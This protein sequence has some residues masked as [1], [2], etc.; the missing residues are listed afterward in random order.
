MT[1]SENKE[2][3]PRSGPDEPVF[4]QLVETVRDY[5][6]FMLDPTGRVV[7]WNEGARRIKGYT[8]ED[9]IGSHFSRFYP[10]EAIDRGWPD[11]ELARAAADGR[12]EDESWRVRKD[13]T[14]FWANVVITALHDADGNLIGFSKVTRDLSE[15][16]RREEALRQSEERF[17][18]LVEGVRDYA[19]FMLDPQGFVTTWTVGAKELQGYEAEEIVGA[20]FSRFYPPDAIKRGWPERELRAA[21]M[22]GRFEDEGWRIRKDGSRFWANVLITALRD[23]RTGALIG[24]SKITRDLTE[25]RRQEQALAQSEER[26]RLLVDGVADYAI[27]MLDPKG[28]VS[29]WNGG[30][31]KLTAYTAQE[32]LGR[33]FSHFYT[34]EEV[35]EHKPWMHLARA[36]ATGRVTDEGWRARKNGSLFWASSITT[37]LHDADGRPYGFAQVMQDLTHRRHAEAL[38]DRAQRMHE[39]I[40]MLAHELRNPLAPI[41][42]AVELMAKKGLPDPTLESMRQTIERQSAHLTRI[43]DELLDVN[44]IARGKFTI[45]KENL[46]VKEVLARAVETSRPLIDSQG[47]RLHVEI[48]PDSLHVQG[49]SVRLTQAMVNLLNN[50]AK[51]TP[52]GGQ[53]WLTAEAHAA[54]VEVR[55]RDSGR[56]ISAEDIERIFDLF[57]Q[58]DPNSTEGRGGLGVG[59]ALVRR[60]VELHAGSVK[61]RSGGP[62]RG[63]EFIVRL[64]LSVQRL[65]GVPD[66][67][68]PDLAAS[69]PTLRVLVVDDNRDAADSLRLLLEAMGQVAYA[70]YDGRLALAAVERF[71]P[72]IVL[73][74]IGM[75]HMNGYD[76]ADQIKSASFDHAPVLAAVTGF[77]QET[78]KRRARDT[79]FEHHFVKPVDAKALQTLLQGVADA[80]QR[81][82][83]RS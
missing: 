52:A 21:T 78:D 28:L 3:G 64:P 30:A 18:A 6:I 81:S 56:G 82:R 46:D 4:R 68:A 22:E 32:I 17:R 37:A 35:A 15:R 45:A 65:K 23:E 70:V 63:S 76:V 75:P 5:G 58:I 25:R 83:D 66:V 2:R 57:A 11:Y 19:I 74:D 26:F 49:D 16:R 62:G 27:V 43:I 8:A 50:A 79:G 13:G 31:E 69:V 44:R 47:H 14:L 10:Q 20:H 38:A 29:S 61:A 7:T 71:Q 9:I 73:L 54:D 33:H 42:N 39:F 40:A 41:R 77:G 36:M 1:D 59:L 53:I 80:R 12:F 48:S 34:S 24:F 72:D 67:K 51:Y 55:V 60:V